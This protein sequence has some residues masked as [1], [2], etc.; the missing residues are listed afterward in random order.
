M[1]YLIQSDSRPLRSRPNADFFR[2]VARA[3][4]DALDLDVEISQALEHAV[5]VRLVDDLDHDQ[6]APVSLFEAAGPQFGGKP[7]T[8][9]T[10]NENLVD[11]S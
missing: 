3:G 11:R 1:R 9:A 10:A 4:I 5:Q 2:L 6:R 8:K 7:V